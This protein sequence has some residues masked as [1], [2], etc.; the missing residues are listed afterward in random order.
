MTVMFLC[1]RRLYTD[2]GVA[3]LVCPFLVR[4]K[5]TF[6]PAERL[7]VFICCFG[8]QSRIRVPFYMMLAYHRPIE[9]AVATDSLCR[10]PVLQAASMQSGSPVE[11]HWCPLYLRFHGEGH[12]TVHATSEACSIR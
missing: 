8:M 7:N 9:T 10:L 1:T 11:V 5:P 2:C 12:A 3:Y 4:I 6:S